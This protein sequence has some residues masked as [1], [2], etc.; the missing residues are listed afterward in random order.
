MLAPRMY[1]GRSLKWAA[2]QIRDMKI[3]PGCHLDRCGRLRADCVCGQFAHN[4][5]LDIGPL[6]LDDTCPFDRRILRRAQLELQPVSRL[7]EEKGQPEDVT[8]TDE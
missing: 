7:S 1:P 5:H 8:Q 4:Q 3:M 2:I 6:D